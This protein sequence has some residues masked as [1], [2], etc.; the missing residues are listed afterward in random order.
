MI[1]QKGTV[2]KGN[3]ISRLFLREIQVDEI[4]F[5][6]AGKYTHH[7]DW[8]SIFEILRGH[9]A[10][11]LGISVGSWFVLHSMGFAPI[12]FEHI[13]AKILKRDNALISKVFSPKIVNSFAL[14]VS[15]HTI[16]LCIGHVHWLGT[17]T[18]WLWKRQGMKSGT[19]NEKNTQL[20]PTLP[21]LKFDIRLM[22]GPV[23]TLNV[24]LPSGRSD[25]V[26]LP[27]KSKVKDLNLLAQQVFGQGFLTS[28]FSKNF[29][30][31]GFWVFFFGGLTV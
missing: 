4:W 24:C 23:V 22:V 3:G 29:R 16:S 6:L 14:L 28:T 11:N 9:F 17:H 27:S 31:V 19:K 18:Q 12:S 13:A 21:S 25:V 1:Y 2:W 20:S 7:L 15:I 5:Y 26:S 8:L 30:S 10:I